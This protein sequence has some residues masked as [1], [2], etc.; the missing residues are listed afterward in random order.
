MRIQLCRE[1]RAGGTRLVD[2]MIGIVLSSMLLAMTGRLGLYCSQSLAAAGNCAEQDAKSRKGLHL[3][4]R[5]LRP[6]TP[7]TGLQNSGN[8]KGLETNEAVVF[9]P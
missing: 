8:A 4:T 6:A 2:L 7:A 3:R 1:K 9:I 5:H